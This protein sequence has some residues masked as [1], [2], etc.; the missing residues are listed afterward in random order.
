MTH[1]AKQ[2]KIQLYRLHETQLKYKDRE[3]LLV[4]VR[5][6]INQTHSKNNKA[7]VTTGLSD[8]R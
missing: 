7:G 4:K 8:R 3:R 1:V 2:D 6:E 5:K